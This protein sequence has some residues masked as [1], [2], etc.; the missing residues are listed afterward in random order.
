MIE[1]PRTRHKAERHLKARS[2]R[3][4]LPLS[5]EET[6]SQKNNYCANTFYHQSGYP[7]RPPESPLCNSVGLVHFD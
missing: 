6:I 1:E 3:H 5:S 2:L 7:Y 4:R